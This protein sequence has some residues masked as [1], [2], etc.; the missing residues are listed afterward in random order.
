M[1]HD[2]PRMGSLVWIAEPTFDEEPTIE[3][4]QQIDQ[5]RWPVF[6]PLSSAL[7]RSIVTP[8][9]VVPIPSALKPFPL[10]RGGNPQLGWQR[11]RIVDCSLPSQ[12]LGPATD[13][14][15]PMYRIV[16]DA[17]LKEMIV[18]GWRPENEW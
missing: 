4:V 13:P 11:V 12:P 6:F 3:Q 2:V 5:W 16:N 18:S 7:R 9:G 17:R 14:S 8:I 15:L 1:T 10:M